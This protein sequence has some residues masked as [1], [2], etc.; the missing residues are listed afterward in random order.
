MTFEPSQTVGLGGESSG[1][2]GGTRRSFFRRKKGCPLSEV[3]AP[4]IDYKNIKL[5]VRFISERGR[6]LPS[7]ITSVSAKKQR[8][9]KRAIKRARSLALLPYISQI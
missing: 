1:E 5:L 8:E 7:R 3:G 2:A 9:L 6:I 4:I